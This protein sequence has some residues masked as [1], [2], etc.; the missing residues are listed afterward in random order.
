MYFNE[1]QGNDFP[2]GARAKF[3]PRDGAFPGAF[4][5]QPTVSIGLT[6]A[7]NRDFI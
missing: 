7:S 1:R 4:P 6:Q 5:D 2:H 3:T